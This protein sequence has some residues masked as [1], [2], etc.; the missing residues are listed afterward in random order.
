[1]PNILVVTT[2]RADYGLLYPLLSKISQS[3]RLDLL[4]AAT[5]YHYSKKHGNTYQFIERDGFTIDFKVPMTQK[6]DTQH[7]VCSSVSKG[8]LEFS[9]IFSKNKIDL[10]VILGDRY[11]LLAVGSAAIIHN[12][13]IAHIHGGELTFGA[14]DD[15]IRHCMSK[16]SILHFTSTQAYANRVIQLG[17][18]PSRVYP[19]GAIG[20]DNIV[21]LEPWTREELSESVGMD[22]SG[23]FAIMT[24]HPTTVDVMGLDYRPGTQVKIIL[25]ELL[26]QG[27]RT[28]ITMPNSDPGADELFQNIKEFIADYPDKFVL[29]KALGRVRYLSVLKYAR[30]MIGNSSSGILESASFKLPVVNIGDR[31]EG[32]IQPRNIIQWSFGEHIMYPLSV[33]V[34]R[35]NS[36]HFRS[37]LEDLE[38]PYGDGHAAEQIVAVLENLDYD[39]LHTY[40]KKG[41][42]DLNQK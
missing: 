21:N 31:Q 9:K 16:M 26:N 15:S 38:N 13:P 4:I 32:R 24:Y 37:T 5:G 40:L 18:D 14:I 1:M 11:E 25:K 12:I 23:D 41:F 6:K 2:G 36:D 7:E 28:I 19:V 30:L 8:V 29:V 33:A 39:N 34:E 20:L 27:L 3:E 35:A 22:L 42:Y 17:E 10:I